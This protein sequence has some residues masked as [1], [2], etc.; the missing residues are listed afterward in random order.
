MLYQI[1]SRRSES[2]LFEGD[3]SDLRAC[4]EAWKHWERTRGNTPLGDE[5]LDI[6]TMFELRI[7][8]VSVQ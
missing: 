4:D 8:R 3:Y 7:Q 2:V 1:K 6:L 5:S